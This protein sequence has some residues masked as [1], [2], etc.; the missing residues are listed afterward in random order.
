MINKKFR[1]DIVGALDYEDF[2]ADIYYEDR[3]L[4]ILTQEEGF[5]NMRISILPPKGA[6]HWDFRFDEFEAAINHAKKR[7]WELR[8]IPE[9][10]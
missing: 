4:A 6:E 2:I 9:D 5:V 7:L 1:I 3:P 10:N 8:V